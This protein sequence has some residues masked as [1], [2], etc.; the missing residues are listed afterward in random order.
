[1]KRLSQFISGFL[2]LMSLTTYIQARQALTAD[3]TF[4]VSTQGSDSNY[5]STGDSSHACL[6][7]PHAVAV[8]QT[9]DLGTFNVTIQ[10]ADG[11][12]T[13]PVVLGLF[14]GGNVILQGNLS[15]PEN[16]VIHTTSA[17]AITVS[18][19]ISTTVQGFKVVTTEAGNEI[20]VTANATLTLGPMEYGPC[21]GFQI[22]AQH[23]TIYI[24]TGYKISGGA[25]VHILAWLQGAI[26]YA[27]DLTV[28]LTGVP[29]F[30][31]QFMYCTD[32]SIMWVFPVTFSGSA[33]GLRYYVGFNS[34]I[35]TNGSGSNFLPGS[36]AGSTD[37]GG[38]YF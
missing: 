36:A 30:A 26:F 34:V 35:E 8:A 17:D 1:M 22:L 31:N 10:V 18:G 25:M 6:T 29:H 4:Y 12:Y 13:S 23:G 15:N 28:T 3:T 24:N 11:T 14:L 27:S 38:Q 19:P 33:T 16:C 7:I 9:F 21:A 2:L 32:V 5:C 37:H 20:Y